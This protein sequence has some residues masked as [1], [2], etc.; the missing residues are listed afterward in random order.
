MPNTTLPSTVN[1]ATFLLSDKKERYD[2]VIS[3]GEDL[4]ESPHFKDHSSDQEKAKVYLLLARA[5]YFSLNNVNRSYVNFISAFSCIPLANLSQETIFLYQ[6]LHYTLCEFELSKKK[7]RPSTTQSYER[8]N[9]H[10]YRAFPEE[11][12][13]RWKDVEDRDILLHYQLKMNILNS[14]LLL[15]FPQSIFRTTLSKRER[16]LIDK[17]GHCAQWV[18]FYCPHDP[19]AYLFLSFCLIRTRHYEMAK[20]YIEQSLRIRKDNTATRLYLKGIIELF[21]NKYSIIGVIDILNAKEIQLIRQSSPSKNMEMNYGVFIKKISN[22][23]DS[24]IEYISYSFRKM[25]YYEEG[26]KE[27]TYLELAIKK[28]I[29]EMQPTKDSLLAILSRLIKK[30]PHDINIY[31]FRAKINL[32]ITEFYECKFIQDPI[33]ANK[34]RESA[35]LDQ[36]KCYELLIE[37]IANILEDIYQHTPLKQSAAIFLRHT[38]LSDADREKISPAALAAAKVRRI[39]YYKLTLEKVMSK[40]QIDPFYKDLA[41]MQEYFLTNKDTLT[42][43]FSFDHL[44]ADKL[45]EM[46]VQWRRSGDMEYFNA[47]PSVGTCSGVI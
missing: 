21:Y 44:R 13:V 37:E 17:L 1:L 42:Y 7:N 34:H 12:T 23:I 41:K 14:L 24:K 45:E 36:V 19:Q 9:Q 40:L 20:Y 22:Y 43:L 11:S 27:Y 29:A 33:A 8:L 5:Y 25:K 35:R 28:T 16:S 10:V 38:I 6:I 30:T 46:I 47:I 31:N 26:S 15:E 18:L 39:E 4:L 3:Y 2:K 32:L